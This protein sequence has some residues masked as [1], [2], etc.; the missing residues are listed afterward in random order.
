MLKK[1]Q[2]FLAIISIVVLVYG[3][4]TKNNII[5]G[6]SGIF[7]SFAFILFEEKN[8]RNIV[9]SVLI[10]IGS[11]GYLYNLDILKLALFLSPFILFCKPKTK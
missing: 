10:I 9:I 6:L 5:I 3:I 2:I 4:W 11:T 8:W 1:Q 7:T